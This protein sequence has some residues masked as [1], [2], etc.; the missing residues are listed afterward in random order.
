MHIGIA[1]LLGGLGYLVRYRRWSWLI[2]G[3]NTSSRKAKEE[4][5]PEAL[6]RGVGG[7]LF[8]LGGSL[9][10][11]ALG[12]FLGRDGLVHLGWALFV[13]ATG[14]FLVYANTGGRYK[15]SRPRDR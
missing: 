3:Y 15:R 1:L 14:V 9:L 10:P 13:V 12:E 6:C 4:Y 8:L 7:F 5:D 2:A 11:A